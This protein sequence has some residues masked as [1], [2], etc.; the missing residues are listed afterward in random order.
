MIVI[1]VVPVVSA[2]QVSVADG[3]A[4]MRR[5]AEVDYL[6]AVRLPCWLHQHDVLRLQISVDQTQLLEK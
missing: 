6:D 4:D 3:L 2:L 1:S 5:A